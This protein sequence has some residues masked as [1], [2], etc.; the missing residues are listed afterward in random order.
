MNKINQSPFY[1]IFTSYIILCRSCF[2]LRNDF[3]A[4]GQMITAVFTVP[5][6]SAFYEKIRPVII[7]S[8]VCLKTTTIIFFFF[9]GPLRTIVV[10]S[11]GFIISFLFKCLN[12]YFLIHRVLGGDLG[13]KRG[14]RYY[15]TCFSYPYFFFIAIG[16][17]RSLQVWA[18]QTILLAVFIPV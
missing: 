9:T 10:P 13:P 6:Q 7:N 18:P 12:G 15:F 3:P 14:K 16:V 8:R 1:F 2:Y 11:L 17:V 4:R 5:F